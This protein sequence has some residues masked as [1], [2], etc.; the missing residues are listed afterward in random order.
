MGRSLWISVLTFIYTERVSFLITKY[1]IWIQWGRKKEN[2]LML[3]AMHCVQLTLFHSAGV[4]FLI[5]S[6]LLLT[7]STHLIFSHFAFTSP[8]QENVGNAFSVAPLDCENFHISVG[9]LN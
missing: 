5:P 1:E 2:L 4:N 6:L 8:F 3:V 9:N 7:P